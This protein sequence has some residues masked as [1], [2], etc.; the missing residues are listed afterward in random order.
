MTP[1]GLILIIYC[2]P[3]YTSTDCIEREKYLITFI[4]KAEIT[5]HTQP[6][7]A[8]YFEDRSQTGDATDRFAKF[9]VD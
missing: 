6:I 1:S 9:L 7:T 5:T 8:Q 4:Y 3:D 2:A